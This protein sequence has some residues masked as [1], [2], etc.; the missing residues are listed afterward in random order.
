MRFQIPVT[1]VFLDF[2]QPSLGKDYEISDLKYLKSEIQINTAGNTE[3][4]SF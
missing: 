2:N 1:E 4:F 3:E